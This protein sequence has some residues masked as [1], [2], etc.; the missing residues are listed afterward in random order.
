MEQVLNKKNDH[1]TIYTNAYLGVLNRTL[2]RG[3]FRLFAGL[4]IMCTHSNTHMAN[5]DVGS[6]L[7]KGQAS[8]CN[9]TAG[10]ITHTSLAHSSHDHGS[11]ELPTHSQPLKTRWQGSVTSVLTSQICRFLHRGRDVSAMSPGLQGTSVGRT[12]VKHY[13]YLTGAAL[14]KTDAR[15][16]SREPR[17]T[18]R[19]PEVHRLSSCSI[20]AWMGYYGLPRLG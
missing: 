9:S 16:N 13:F 7:E 17:L 14:G 20:M 15:R 3:K 12:T 19:N 2:N 8:R 4:S 11:Q 6:M 1:N 10:R 5:G 18:R